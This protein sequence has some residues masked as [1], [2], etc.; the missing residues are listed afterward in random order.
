MENSMK[1]RVFVTRSSVLALAGAVPASLAQLPVEH[2][3][4]E[5]L[6][7]EKINVPHPSIHRIEADGLTV[8]YREAGPADAPTVLLLHGF[9]TS[10]FQYRELIPRLAD[11]YRVIAPDLPG[12]GFTEVPEE[13]QYKYTFDALAN[14]IL[15]FTDAMHLKRYALYVFDYG[16]PIGFRLAMARPDRITAMVSQ[17]GNAYEEGLG[18]AWAPI[19]R[20]W[21]Q[22]TSENRESIRKGLTRPSD[23]SRA[24]TGAWRPWHP[25]HVC[26]GA[27][28]H[29][30]AL[31]RG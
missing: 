5:E 14:T 18:D 23:I 1:R 4:K 11:R 25:L 21:S 31:L 19:R 3:K 15:A 10:S 13:R 2:F 30:H 22:P 12:F 7:V 26:H 16:A 27:G 20:Y 6:M 9:P 24:T 29:F 17:N 8:F 28:R